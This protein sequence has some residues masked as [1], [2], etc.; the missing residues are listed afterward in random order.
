MQNR[1]RGRD[2]RLLAR[3]NRHPEHADA[4]FERVT[5]MFCGKSP[6]RFRP[7]MVLHKS[8]TKTKWHWAISLPH[9]DL[10]AFGDA[11]F[12]IADYTLAMVGGYQRSHVGLRLRS[13]TDSKLA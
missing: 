8:C 5:G 10:G 7:S 11:F 3:F 4:G 1:L 9:Q 6:T 2:R 13:V 12:D